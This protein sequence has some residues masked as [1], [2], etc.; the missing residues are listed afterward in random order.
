M[1]R[2][3]L[4]VAL[5]AANLEGLYHANLAVLDGLVACEALDVV[6]GYVLEVGEGLLAEVLES[7]DVASVAALLGDLALASGHFHVALV[8]GHADLQV[9]GVAEGIAFVGDHIGGSLVARGASRYGLASGRTLE[10]AKETDLLGHGDVLALD[11]LAVARGAVELLSAADLG[12]VVSVVEED[13]LL[14]K[15]LS[16][17]EALLVASFLKTGRIGHF[18]P[19]PGIVGAEPVAEGGGGNEA[20][21]D[22]VAVDTGNLVVARGLPLLVVGLHVVASEAEARVG[23]KGVE[24]SV[25]DDGGENDNARDGEE[26]TFGAAYASC[27]AAQSSEHGLRPLCFQ[28]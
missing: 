26:R 12:Y 11:N 2:V 21:S 17:K 1:R 19:R 7:L 28:V 4:G 23:A 14:E 10:V 9:G 20:W 25:V 15:D 8:A 18:G 27:Q 13:I 5:L 22:G 3:L 24:D 6:L 16:L